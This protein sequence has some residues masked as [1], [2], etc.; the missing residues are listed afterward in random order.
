[1]NITL[2]QGDTFPPVDIT[3]LN[4]DGLPLSLPTGTLVRFHMGTLR[5]GAAFLGV[6]EVLDAAA[7][8]ISYQWQ[9]GDTDTPGGFLAEFQLTLPDGRVLTVPNNDWIEVEIVKQ[10]G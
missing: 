9:P 3:V 8:R 2:K 7:G 6:G 10:L 5:T 4:P 1:M